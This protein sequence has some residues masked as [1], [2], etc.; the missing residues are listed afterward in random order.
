MSADGRINP[1]AEPSIETEMKALQNPKLTP[2]ER[3]ARATDAY[4]RLLKMADGYQS[5]SRIP[6]KVYKAAGMP[7]QLIEE[8]KQSTRN[9]LEMLRNALHQLRDM[10]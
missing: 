1:R 2:D 4:E 3:R 7:D 8:R 5:K 10:L 9:S 6:E